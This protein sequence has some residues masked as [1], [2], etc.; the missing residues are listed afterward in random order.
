MKVK[1]SDLTGPALDWAVA[2]CEELAVTIDTHHTTG[3]CIFDTELLNMEVDSGAQYQPSTNWAQGG[4]II[5]REQI[6]ISFISSDTDS[7]GFWAANSL[8]PKSHRDFWPYGYGLTPLISAMRCYVASK[9][10]ESVEIPAELVIAIEAPKPA[11][12]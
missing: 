8:R 9:L 1:T 6:D 4:P 2:K 7:P 10:G 12:D 5:E 11:K 3:I